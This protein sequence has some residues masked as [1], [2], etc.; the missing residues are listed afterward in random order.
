MTTVDEANYWESGRVVTVK[1]TTTKTTFRLNNSIIRT[2]T[3]SGFLDDEKYT[4]GSSEALYH[5]PYS[6]SDLR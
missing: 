6:N 5:F 3:T 4:V 1:S 2:I